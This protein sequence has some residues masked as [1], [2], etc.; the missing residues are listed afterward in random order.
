M[1]RRPEKNMHRPVLDR[2]SFREECGS[3]LSGMGCGIGLVW[4]KCRGGGNYKIRV[5]RRCRRRR[6]WQV[7]DPWMRRGS[8]YYLFHFFRNDFVLHWSGMNIL[9]KICG[10]DIL[11]LERHGI[12]WVKFPHLLR[13]RDYSNHNFMRRIDGG[14]N[15]GTTSSNCNLIIRIEAFKI[16]KPE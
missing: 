3:A 14:R 6:W 16:R 5:G 11:Y 10:S 1:V 8:T 9:L 4:K 2:T 7:P 15:K 13:G 12:I